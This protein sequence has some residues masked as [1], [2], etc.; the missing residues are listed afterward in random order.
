MAVSKV[1]YSMIRRAVHQGVIGRGFG[2]RLPWLKSHHTPEPMSLIQ[3]RYSEP[4]AASG[5]REGWGEDAD[6]TYTHF[7]LLL[8]KLPPKLVT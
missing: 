4:H 8:N 6:G 7:L 5:K 2:A 1:K 3:G